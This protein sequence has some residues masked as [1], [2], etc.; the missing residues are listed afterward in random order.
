MK[1]LLILALALVLPLT[2]LNAHEEREG[3]DHPCRRIKQACSA[4][5]YSKGKKEGKGLRRDC[6]RPL[7]QGQNVPG[8]NVKASDVVA[9]QERKKEHEARHQ[10]KNKKHH[11]EVETTEQADAS[12]G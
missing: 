3:K 2:S 7:L 5:G 4:A 6:M 9:C 1:M 12:E 10:R 8:V 11:D